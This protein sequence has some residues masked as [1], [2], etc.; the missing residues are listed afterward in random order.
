[1]AK[2]LSRFSEIINKSTEYLSILS[3][4]YKINESSKLY[5]KNKWFLYDSI[6][7]KIVFFAN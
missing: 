3:L 7:L 2:V 4:M 6:W 5:F 1:M